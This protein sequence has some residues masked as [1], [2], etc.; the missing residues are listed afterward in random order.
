MVGCDLSRT[1][2]KTKGE[3]EEMTHFED[4]KNP[5]KF[6]AWKKLYNKWF[7]YH[8]LARK[9]EEQNTHYHDTSAEARFLV[10][11]HRDMAKYYR[12]KM[13]KYEVE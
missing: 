13:E 11:C 2:S 8:R 4:W 9:S 12:T 7:Y 5:K 6:K 1:N 10:Q 3:K